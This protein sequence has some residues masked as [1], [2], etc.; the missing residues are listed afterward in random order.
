M[1]HLQV[2]LDDDNDIIMT[3]AKRP[4]LKV[5]L[6]SPA[7]A[8]TEDDD[9]KD[10]LTKRLQTPPAE[11][12]LRWI[13]VDAET[14]HSAECHLVWAKAESPRSQLLYRWFECVASSACDWYTQ[15]DELASDI[16]E[17]CTED[18]IFA[19][20][21][22]DLLDCV[23][24]QEMDDFLDSCHFKQFPVSPARLQCVTLLT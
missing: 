14:G 21:L 1:Q 11:R 10:P 15:P 20:H 8:W 23:S 19:S 12:W 16:G 18:A 4:C 22:R 9:N 3:P 6:P 24:E 7:P 5:V 17:P 13:T 2:Y